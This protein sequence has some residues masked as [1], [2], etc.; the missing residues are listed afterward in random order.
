MKTTTLILASIILAAHFAAPTQAADFIARCQLKG[1]FVPDGR[2]TDS[3]NVTV[4]LATDT[5]ADVQSF[6]EGKVFLHLSDDR[7]SGKWSANGLLEGAIGAGAS[8]DWGAGIPFVVDTTFDIRFSAPLGES[9]FN[10]R[11]GVDGRRVHQFFS[12]RQITNDL[13]VGLSGDLGLKLLGI[14][15]AESN[16]SLAASFIS[17]NTVLGTI[18]T[19]STFQPTCESLLSDTNRCSTHIPL[20]GDASVEFTGPTSAH[21]SAFTYHDFTI[22]QNSEARIDDNSQRF[23]NPYLPNLF[24]ENAIQTVPS[25]KVLSAREAE[26]G[27]QLVILGWTSDSQIHLAVESSTDLSNWDKVGVPV[28]SRVGTNELPLAPFSEDTQFFRLVKA[29]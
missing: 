24:V 27:G 9:T 5:P 6:Q 13:P 28:V 7:L 10:L 22:F 19:D 23:H 3:A 25:V 16:P 17:T 4:S 11:L 12:S 29:E 8:T 2:F 21:L 1:F 14:F 18:A 26:V 20:A 15:P